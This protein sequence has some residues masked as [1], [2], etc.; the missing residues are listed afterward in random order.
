A[1]A[2][3]EQAVAHADRSGDAIQRM[4]FRTT[5]AD[6]LHQAGRRAGEGG[7]EAH[8]RAAEQR[9]AERQP[10]HPLL[11]SVQGF[12]YCDLLLP[13]A[14]R[15]AWLQALHIRP[16]SGSSDPR[17]PHPAIADVRRRA[18]Q[19]LV[20]VTPLNWLLDIALDHLTLGRAA[21]YESL[22]SSGPE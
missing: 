1:I 2:D 8:F 10:S 9:L 21:L 12:R 18:E 6:A 20:W 11:C 7:A 14:E 16:S 22:L 15:G 5:L 3:A 13:P 17:V 19:T 4:A